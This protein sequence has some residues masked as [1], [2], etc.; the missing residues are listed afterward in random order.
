MRSTCH[1]PWFGIN[2]WAFV[3]SKGGLFVPLVSC[4]HLGT[5]SSSLID[6]VSV[7]GEGDSYVASFVGRGSLSW[8]L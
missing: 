8:T 1:S 4:P 7:S 3:F 2:T 5:Q 6:E